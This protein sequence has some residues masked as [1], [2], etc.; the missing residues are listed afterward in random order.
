MARRGRALRGSVWAI[1]PISAGGAR[2]VAGSFKRLA[3]VHDAETGVC[4]GTI[5]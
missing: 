4:L 2:F 3:K 5:G 1:V